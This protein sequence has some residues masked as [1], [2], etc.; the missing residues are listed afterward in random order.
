MNDPKLVNRI[1][2]YLC[3]Q[4]EIQ[5]PG[6][7]YIFRGEIGGVIVKDTQVSILF[8]WLAK[9]EGY[10]P[11]P[12][13]WVKADP[14]PYDI[15]LEIYAVSDIGD[16]RLCLNSSIVGETTVLFPH[17]GSSLDTSKVEGLEQKLAR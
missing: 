10:P 16:G 6:E 12:T 13:K 1:K 7:R 9:G 15:D 11:I 5:N 4:A 14:K 8:S 2:T 3:G 17:N